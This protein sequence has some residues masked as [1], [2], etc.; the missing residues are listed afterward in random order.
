MNPICFRQ[1]SPPTV[2][3][4]KAIG[5]I[6]SLLQIQK[7][8]PIIGASEERPPVSII[9]PSAPQATGGSIL[10]PSAATTK[11][12]GSI[13]TP[14]AAPKPAAKLAAPKT[15]GPLITPGP[16]P[17]PAAKLV[18]PGGKPAELPS[19]GPG[20]AGYRPPTKSPHE[21]PALELQSRKP[22]L[23]TYGAGAP[24]TRVMPSH[25]GRE[26]MMASPKKESV[27]LEVP[28]ATPR[29]EAEIETPGLKPAAGGPLI[30]PSAK[31]EL[32]VAGR[33]KEIIGEGVSAITQG[34]GAERTAAMKRAGAML[35]HRQREREAEAPSPAAGA[36]NPAMSLTPPAT[37][38]GTLPPP[39]EGAAARGKT[40]RSNPS[41]PSQAAA[42]AGVGG[43]RTGAA[44]QL[45]ARAKR[46]M[47][48]N[49]LGNFGTG[50]QIGLQGGTLGGGAATAA[51]LAHKVMGAA[52]GV[53]SHPSPQERGRSDRDAYQQ[54]AEMLRRM[55]DQAAR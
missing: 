29:P 45:S 6:S 10:N 37:A 43:G 55:S 14:G 32:S 16:A 49:I 41:Q 5:G 7:A 25:L 54:R 53:A 34:S 17:R 52:H 27:K 9:H 4:G 47:G 12:S 11:P 19:F 21:G 26:T 36:A 38:G 18:T 50:Y 42:G 2:V 1:W 51:M 8:T 22:G 44:P 24:V 31:P 30:V 15:G 35:S 3:G 33:Q 13:I 28:G 23:T 39:P 40:G 46:A 48:P 20:S